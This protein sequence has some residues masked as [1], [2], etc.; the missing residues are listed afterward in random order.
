MQ[1]GAAPITGNKKEAKQEAC[2][3]ALEYAKKINY[4][5]RQKESNKTVK[6]ALP[7]TDGNTDSTI[8]SS[9]EK[10]DG[11]LSETNKGFK[12]LKMLGWK[13]GALGTDGTGIQEPIKYC[14]ST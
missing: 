5:V 8:T 12:M 10:D 6:V 4:T 11:K 9:A 3:K 7:E 1:Y 14:Y 2:T 13:G